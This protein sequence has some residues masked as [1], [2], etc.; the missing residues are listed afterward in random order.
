MSSQARRRLAPLFALGLTASIA[1]ACDQM[2]PNT[3]RLFLHGGGSED[4]VRATAARGGPVPIIVQGSAHPDTPGAALDG[5]IAAAFNHAL[6]GL[7]AGFAVQAPTR[8]DDARIVLALQPGQARSAI[9][10][11]RGETLGREQAGPYEVIGAI[12]VGETVFAEAR[13]WTNRESPP[14]HPDLP[15]LFEQLARELIAPPQNR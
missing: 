12:C 1:G 8:D 7:M 10:L 14:N 15:Q 3:Q 13:G 6:P 4:A 2:G 9:R 5:L 11:C